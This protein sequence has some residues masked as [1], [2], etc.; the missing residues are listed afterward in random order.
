ML[1]I[2]QNKISIGAPPFGGTGL[3]PDVRWDF[4]EGAKNL[5]A[6]SEDPSNAVWEQRG[7]TV[8]EEGPAHPEG[9]RV[10]K[11]VED[12]SDGTHDLR[13]NYNIP[14]T[15][16]NFYVLQADFKAGAN[17][18]VAIITW[19]PFTAGVQYDLN[20]GTVSDDAPDKE[21]DFGI[22]SLGDGWYRCWLEWNPDGSD[23]T[24]TAKFGNPGSYVGDGSSEFYVANFI[25]REGQGGPITPYKTTDRDTLPT[26]IG[27]SSYD[28]QLG[29][30]VG[31]DTNDPTWEPE[32]GLD[33]DGTDDQIEGPNNPATTDWTVIWATGSEVR[34]V[35][36]AGGSFQDGSSGGGFTIAAD[37]D[38]STA[39]GYSGLLTWRETYE[40]VLSASEQQ[41]RYEDI[42]AEL[43]TYSNVTIS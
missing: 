14:A 18:V 6:W 37:H 9:A 3:T 13:Q 41:E 39:G 25:V 32:I 5:L 28:M 17:S 20:A 31:A 29:S 11:V 36:S 4:T 40:R 19:Q 43:N 15:D 21:T 42:K 30:A 12:T 2:Y 16:T 38:I 7:V 34:S 27:S 1:S 10:W 24:P 33:F 22:E 8:T 23:T 35:D 26:L